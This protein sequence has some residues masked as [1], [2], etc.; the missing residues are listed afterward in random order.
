MNYDI[1]HKQYK[2]GN[3]VY[4]EV[5]ARFYLHIFRNMFQQTTF[6]SELNNV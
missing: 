1:K 5:M 4:F 2:A 3:H 6:I